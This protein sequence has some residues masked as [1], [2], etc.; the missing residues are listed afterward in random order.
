MLRRLLVVMIVTVILAV[1]IG[2]AASLGTI[3]TGMVGA[4]DAVVASCDPDGVSV[5]YGLAYDNGRY[6]VKTVT[7]GGIADQCVGGTLLFTLTKAGSGIASGSIT[8]NSTSHTITVTNP[9]AADDVDDVHIAI[10]G[11]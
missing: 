9:P 10:N 2:A 11:P 5:A 1:A 6:E 7:V 4:G 8:V 3:T